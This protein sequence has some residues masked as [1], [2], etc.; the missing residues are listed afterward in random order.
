MARGPRTA[1]STH[2]HS[3][4]TTPPTPNGT[5]PGSTSTHPPGL[6]ENCKVGQ[7]LYATQIY[8]ADDADVHPLIQLTACGLA[9]GTGWGA[10]YFASK[11]DEKPKDDEAAEAMA[12]RLAEA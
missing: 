3:T 9:F 12:K 8:Y 1:R 11:K 7:A 5:T 6:A 2:S 4:T 10:A